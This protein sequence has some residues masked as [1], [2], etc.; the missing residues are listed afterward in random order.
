VSRLPRQK[1]FA[2]SYFRDRAVVQA[3]L[4]CDLP[5]GE[6]GGDRIGE[7]PAPCLA[8]GHCIALEV[9]LGIANGFSGS[10]TLS[11]RHRRSLLLQLAA[12]VGQRQHKTLQRPAKR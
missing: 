3:S 5:Q 9:R 10:E 6:P 4:L 1:L 7:G 8:H 11:I 2:A 12:H